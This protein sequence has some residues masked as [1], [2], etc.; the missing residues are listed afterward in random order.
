MAVML[1]LEVM[2]VMVVMW[3]E[4]VLTTLRELMLLLEKLMVVICVCECG[5]GDGVDVCEC[6]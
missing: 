3:C 6:V 5:E 4:C 1:L 2:L